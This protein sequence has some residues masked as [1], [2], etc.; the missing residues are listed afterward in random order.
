MATYNLTDERQIDRHV[1]TVMLADPML[2]ASLVASI[3]QFLKSP[4]ISIAAPE[5]ETKGG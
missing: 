4:T 5:S 1:M 3:E 2:V